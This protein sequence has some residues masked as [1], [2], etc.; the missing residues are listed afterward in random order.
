MSIVAYLLITNREFALGLL[1][2][3]GESLEFL[4]GLRLQ[5]LDTKPDV[6]LCVLVTRLWLSQCMQLQVHIYFPP[7]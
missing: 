2:L 5:D 1:V 7:T 4:H 3:I 6:A